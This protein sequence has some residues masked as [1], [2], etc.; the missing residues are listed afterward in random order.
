MF[1]NQL[2]P[3]LSSYIEQRDTMSIRSQH[4]TLSQVPTQGEMMR[5]IDGYA[6]RA[7]YI[8]GSPNLAEMQA[9]SELIGSRLAHMRMAEVK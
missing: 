3:L 7:H 6:A 4:L 9:L 5:M 2:A 8:L 1:T